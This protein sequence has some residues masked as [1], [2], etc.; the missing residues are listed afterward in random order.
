MEQGST[1]EHNGWK[2]R[3]SVPGG[4]WALPLPNG[5]HCRPVPRSVLAMDGRSTVRFTVLLV[6]RWMVLK[7]MANSE[8]TTH[9]PFQHHH[10]GASTGIDCL[11]PRWRCYT[12]V[13]GGWTDRNE[14]RTD[15]KTM[16]KK[17]RCS[18]SYRQAVGPFHFV[19][20]VERMRCLSPCAQ[21]IKTEHNR[22][23]TDRQIIDW[24]WAVCCRLVSGRF[25]VSSSRAR[26]T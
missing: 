16:R 7:T 13:A 24:F 15:G 21:L 10:L 2:R 14:R 25:L 1:R 6:R 22:Q 26:Q 8:P 12:V 9:Q 17:E 20:V 3:D 5:V 11:K 4:S 19:S 23:P 18:G